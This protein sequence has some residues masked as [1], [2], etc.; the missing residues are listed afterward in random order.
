MDMIRGASVAR[1]KSR[2]H[3]FGSFE[4]FAGQFPLLPFL[5]S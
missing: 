2:V 4:S 1:L 5:G 3:T